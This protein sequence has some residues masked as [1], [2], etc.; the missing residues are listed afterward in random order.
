MSI[1]KVIIFFALV[2]V[3]S[4][5]AFARHLHKENEYQRA[6]CG[7]AGG[8]IE[9]RLDDGSRVDCV[10]EEYAIEFDFARKWAE[11]VGQALYYAEKTGKKPG[12]VLIMEG[13]KPG[14]FLKRLE[15]IAGRYNIKVWSMAAI[16]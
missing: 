1:K 3:L 2:S 12:I 14:R 16:N 15:F 4:S 6:W 13:K 7:D 5:T 9:Y 8:V 10:T 11:A